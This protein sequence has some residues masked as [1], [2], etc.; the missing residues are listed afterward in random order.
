MSRLD[1]LTASVSSGNE[2]DF[3]QIESA[4]ATLVDAQTADEPKAAFLKALRLKGE[5]AGEIAG[6]VNALLARAVDPQ[7]NASKLSGPMLD[8]CG[9]G[10]DRMELFNVSTTAMFVLAAGGAVVV[11]H[12][13]R[14]ITSKCGG[15]DVLEFL[16]VKIDL[17]PEKLRRC[18]EENGVGFL[19]APHYHPAFKAIAPVRKMLAAQGVTT[20]FNMLGPLMNPSRPAHQLVGVFA[21]SLLQKFA[22]TFLLLH[23]KHAWAVHGASDTGLGVDEISTMGATQVCKVGDGGI[24]VETL[25]PEHFGFPRATAE[26]L[27]GGDCAQNARILH[28]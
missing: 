15:A 21:Q 22:Q 14:G 25:H 11:K 26:E 4:I 28:G 3:T 27:R 17:P 10:G 23:R 24:E 12:G 6:F 9:T 18:V 20:I 16:G 13:N 8:V 7:I 19:F 5:T 1:E 2:L